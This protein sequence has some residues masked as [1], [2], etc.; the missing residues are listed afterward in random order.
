MLQQHQYIYG[1]KPDEHES[2]KSCVI[3]SKLHLQVVILWKKKKEEKLFDILILLGQWTAGKSYF[4]LTFIDLHLISIRKMT[5]NK[6]ELRNF[7][8][9]KDL[10]TD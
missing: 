4:C 5:K 1:N 10:T 8:L 2:N 3:F 9:N 7:H 6:I